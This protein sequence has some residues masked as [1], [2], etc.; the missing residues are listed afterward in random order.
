MAAG[1][2][3]EG[4]NTTKEEAGDVD[5]CDFP[6]LRQETIRAAGADF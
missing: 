6:V 4:G 2:R 5:V 1:A 3:G